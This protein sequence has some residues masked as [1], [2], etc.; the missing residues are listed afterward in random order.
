MDTW[1]RAHWNIS[2][3]I[4]QVATML[5]S[6][7]LEFQWWRRSPGFPCRVVHWLRHI[8]RCH[9]NTERVRS[10]FRSWN[11]SQQRVTWKQRWRA[12][13]YRDCTRHNQSRK[14]LHWLQKPTLDESMG[15]HLLH[16]EPNRPEQVEKGFFSHLNGIAVQECIHLTLSRAEHW[17]WDW[18]G[19]C[20]CRTCS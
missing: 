3:L 2:R 15:R 17:W 8:H 18:H 16:L 5:N 19:F 11:S 20:P 10:I 14:I 9:G 4:W 13:S 6:A 1:N 7:A 12:W